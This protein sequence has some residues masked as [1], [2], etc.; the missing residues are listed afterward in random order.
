MMKIAV[1]FLS[2]TMYQCQC[3]PDQHF[4]YPVGGN[5]QEGLSGDGE[6]AKEAS[7]SSPYF[8]L[9]GKDENFYIADNDNDVIRKIDASSKTITTFAGQAGKGG[10]IVNVIATQGKLNNPR[11]IIDDDEGNFFISDTLNN[12]IKKV[13]NKGIITLY[14]GGGS[15][16]ASSP[17]IGVSLKDVS[18]NSPVGLF[19]N[20]KKEMYLCDLNNHVIRKIDMITETITLFAGVVGVSG[21]SIDGVP[22][23]NSILRRPWGVYQNKKGEI[24]FTERDNGVIRMVKNG[25][26]NTI[27]GS[28]GE[29]GDQDDENNVKLSKK[30]TGLWGDEKGNIYFS[31][32]ENH[33]IKKID[34]D[35]DITTLVGTGFITYNGEGL[36]GKNTNIRSPTGLFVTGKGEIYFAESNNHMVRVGIPLSGQNGQN[37]SGGMSSDE[38]KCR[39]VECL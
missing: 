25:V 26:L 32:T 15:N 39:F 9:K 7:L 17:S 1:L 3:R 28:L 36:S 8:L 38:L 4:V 30:L 29:Y 18:L 22:A 12:K 24:F 27:A 20:N 14:A 10:D 23:F 21:M 19:I 31:D 6:S 2:M 5:G 34:D 35:G 16:S 11:F 13:D 33:K 37:V